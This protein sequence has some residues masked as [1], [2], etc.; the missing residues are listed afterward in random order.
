MCE[1]FDPHAVAQCLEED[2]EEVRDKLRVNFCEWYKP[3][4]GAF[5]PARAAVQERARADLDAL[6][7]DADEAAATSDALSEAEKLFK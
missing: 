5:D 6:F 1:Y 7:G 3:D 4:Y 2:A